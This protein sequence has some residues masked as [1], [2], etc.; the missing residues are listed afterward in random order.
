MIIH[1]EFG[2]NQSSF[3]EKLLFIFSWGPILKLCPVILDFQ[4]TC[5]IQ[6]LY[7]VM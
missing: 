6:T 7:R 1:V 4:S 5:K 3:L 2:L